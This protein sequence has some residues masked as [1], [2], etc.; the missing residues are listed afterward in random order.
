MVIGDMPPPSPRLPRGPFCMPLKTSSKPM[1][2]SLFCRRARARV[3]TRQRSGVG[4]V[5][6]ASAHGARGNSA[7][8]TTVAKADATG[9]PPSLLNRYRRTRVTPSYSQ[10]R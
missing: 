9:R 5:A 3:E 8:G 1:I 10:T 7:S 4:Y 6:C 2:A